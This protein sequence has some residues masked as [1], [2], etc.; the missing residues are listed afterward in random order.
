MSLMKHF[1]KMKNNHDATVNTLTM[2]GCVTMPLPQQNNQYTIDD[3]YALP[4]G[5]RAD[6]YDG[7]ADTETPTDTRRS[8]S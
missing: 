2:K 7:S 8:L 4:D 1:G 5:Q 6:V 3:I